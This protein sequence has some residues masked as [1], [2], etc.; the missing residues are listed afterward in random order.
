MEALEL[1]LIVLGAEKVHP[2][3]FSNIMSNGGTV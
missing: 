2:V 1:T 3:L